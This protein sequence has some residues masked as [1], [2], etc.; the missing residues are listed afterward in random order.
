MMIIVRK[1]VKKLDFIKKLL[2]LELKIDNHSINSRNYATACH[3]TSEEFSRNLVPKIEKKFKKVKKLEK[4]ANI[5]KNCLYLI[6]EKHSIAS[7]RYVVAYNQNLEE[8]MWLLRLEKPKKKFKK[9]E[10]MQVLSG[11]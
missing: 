5:F 9:L 6:L 7:R 1:F 2:K 11:K 10:K 3:Q 8:V 4:I